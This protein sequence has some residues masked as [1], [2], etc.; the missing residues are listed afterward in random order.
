MT[1]DNPQGIY[2]KLENLLKNKDFREAFYLSMIA[3]TYILRES[4]KEA[5]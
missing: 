4:C 3:M 1:V 5:Q 2:T